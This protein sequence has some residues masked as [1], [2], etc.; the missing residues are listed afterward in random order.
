MKKKGDFFHPHFPSTPHT[1][2][3]SLLKYLMKVPSSMGRLSR[4]IEV[5]IL[6]TETGSCMRTIIH[7]LHLLAHLSVSDSFSLLEADPQKH[8]ANSIS[9]VA[10]AAI[11]QNHG[12]RSR[13][14]PAP[15]SHPVSPNLQVH[16]CG[17]FFS[18]SPQIG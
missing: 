10:P 8:H 9:T 14:F 1:A 7:S 18:S 4:V 12:I 2:L 11:D 16:S 17:C 13:P 3:S 15:L 5:Y 6:L